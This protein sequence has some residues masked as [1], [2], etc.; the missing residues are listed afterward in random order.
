MRALTLGKLGRSN[1]DPFRAPRTSRMMQ[2]FEFAVRASGEIE[3]SAVPTSV[4]RLGAADSMPGPDPMSS[5]LETDPLVTI[6]IPT[7][8]RATWLRDC[9]RLAL[10]QSYPR[11]EVLVSDN[12]STDETAL[13]LSQFKDERL[14][15][16]RQLKNV[17]ATANWN[18]CVAQA[19]GEYIVFVPDD[20]RI[21][22]WLLERCISVIRREPQVPIV[23]ALG[24]ARV[25]ASGRTLP[26]L[27][28]RNFKTGVWDGLDILEEY[29]K[30][31]ITVQGC[32]TMLRSERLRA[33]GGFPMGWPFAG[34]LARHLPLLLEGKAGFVNECCGSY[35]LHDATQTSHLALERHLDDIRKLVDLITHTAEERIKDER[36]RRQLQLQAKHFLARQAVGILISYRKRGAEL[37]DLRP[38]LWKWQGRLVALR[39]QDF[40][41]AMTLFCWLLLPAPLIAWLRSIKRNLM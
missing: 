3:N 33:S 31:R 32:T 6:A 5:T 30:Q 9:V 34:D 19:R 22:P 20:D 24:E 23:M 7:F 2:V 37:S 25:V 15:V 12:A 26:P 14:R 18:A 27:A 39:A 40:F 16:V 8:N 38:V 41:N 11:F 28:S 4:R 35:S 1:I 13:V 21:A 10:M 29:L 36:R 17:V